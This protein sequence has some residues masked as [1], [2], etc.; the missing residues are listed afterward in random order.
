M[1]TSLPTSVSMP[2]PPVPIPVPV[3]TPTPLPVSTTGPMPTPTSND[4]PPIQTGFSQSVERRSGDVES[5]FGQQSDLASSRG[6][7][8]TSVPSAISSGAKS[9]LQVGVM[10]TAEQVIQP[11]NED[12]SIARCHQRAVECGFPAGPIHGS[13]DHLEEAVRRWTRDCSTGGGGHGIRKAGVTPAKKRGPRARFQCCKDS[14]R[15]E[16]CKW[17]CTFEET[18]EGWVL[19]SAVWNHNGHELLAQQAEVMAAR[20]TA[21]LPQ[22]LLEL[23]TDAAEAGQSIKDIDNLLRKTAQ[24]R[25]IPITW[26]PT[27]LRSRFNVR[28]AAADFD[29]TDFVATL[30]ARESNANTAFELHCNDRGVATHIFV[31]LENS[32]QDWA[33]DTSHVL[34]F[35]P[36]WGTHRAGMKLCCFT[37][38]SA[39]GQSVVLA[40]ALLQDESADSILWCFRGFAKHF[41]RPPTVLFTDDAV[42]I[43]IAF[44][45]MHDA[46]AWSGTSH[47]LCTYHLA[48]N[49]FK[50]VRPL[51]TDKTAWHQL[52]S[53]FWH[54]AKFSD[55]RF[56]AEAE[57]PC[58]MQQFDK[59]AKG[60]TKGD[61]KVWLESLFTRR[62][63]W[64]AAITWSLTTWGVHSTQRAEAIHSALKSR[65]LKNRSCVVLL[66][67]I[68]DYN[69]LSR[70]RKEADDIRKQ[71]RSAA[72]VS[73]VPP[74]LCELQSTLT[75][76]AFDLVMSQFSLSVGYCSS[77]NDTWEGA[78]SDSLDSFVVKYAGA[79]KR[80]AFTPVLTEDGT[81]TSWQCDADFG[82]G[83]FPGHAGHIATLRTCSCQFGNVFQLPCRHMLHLHLQ[84]QVTALQFECSSRWVRKPADVELRNLQALRAMPSPSTAA[85]AP[86]SGI[87]FSDRRSIL[88]DDFLPLIDAAARNIDLFHS[89]RSSLPALQHAVQHNV[90]L[91]IPFSSAE[92]HVEEVQP[93]SAPTERAQTEDQIRIRKLLGTSYI[94]VPLA[95]QD[96]SLQGRTVLIKYGTKVWHMAT[97]QS[98]PN[99][100]QLSKVQYDD[101]DT[102]LTRLTEDLEWDVLQNREAPRWSWLLLDEAPL[103]NHSGCQVTEARESNQGRKRT[104]RAAPAYG[105]TAKSA[106]AAK[107]TKGANKAKG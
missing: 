27:H 84:Q 22:E 47:L 21:F 61:A 60:A 106:K 104:Q 2:I 88:L 81:I 64:M 105:P 56:D 49:F 82:L 94:V 3:S 91:P 80:T 107:Q 77:P 68:T 85:N 101:G 70:T 26:E 76:Y 71:L 86:S 41:K 57:W 96:L 95:L 74:F 5:V 99:D 18:K 4:E 30:K 1:P 63:Q 59:V 13:A 79:I 83:D 10:R 90:I 78:L 53:W 40:F 58:F 6:S 7:H 98:N 24:R 87:S 55:L 17:E 72:G 89:F 15:K 54:F 43:S 28:S 11:L 100:E 73:H 14:S 52:N 44:T 46:G 48:K 8:C 45:S 51:V 12:S 23:G 31:Q 93:K 42:S 25:N 35:D 38:V 75:G 92:V 20:G 103:S 29:L 67:E 9:S 97:V 16:L 62:R 50:H 39:L 32:L 69:H 33:N 19:V 66:Q 102:G 36:T 37:T 34:L 65:K